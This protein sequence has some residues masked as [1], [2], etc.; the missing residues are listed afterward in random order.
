MVKFYLLAFSRF[1]PRKKKTKI[2]VS[3]RI[4]LATCALVGERGYLLDHSGDIGA[5]YPVPFFLFYSI[6][7]IY[8]VYVVYMRGT[9]CGSLFSVTSMN[10]RP[11][12]TSTV[13]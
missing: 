8:L 1:L 7:L 13:Q 11:Y 12:F 3:T 6:Y 5:V 4:E 9:H 2:L 10:C